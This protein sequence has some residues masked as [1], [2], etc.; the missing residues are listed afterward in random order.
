MATNKNK[1]IETKQPVDQYVAHIKDEK[2]RTD[3]VKIMELF[4]KQTKLEPKMWGENIVG[5]GSYHYKYESGRE[6]DAPLTGIASRAANITLYLG[7]DFE[8]SEELL[9]RLGKYKM[10]GGCIHIKK[11]EEIDSKV[12]EEIVKKSVAAKRKKHR[13]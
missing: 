2:K 4:A 5:F 1:T 11:L 8:N 9:T 12:L 7:C 13:R 6:G 10:N 3:F